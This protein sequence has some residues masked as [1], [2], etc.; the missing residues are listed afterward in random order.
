M[1]DEELNGKRILAVPLN[2]GLGHATRLVPLLQKCIDAGAVIIIGGSPQHIS[3]MGEI[4]GPMETVS[5]PYLNIRLSPHRSQVGILLIQLPAIIVTIIREHFTLRQIVRNQNIDMVIS[6]NCFGLWNR[7]VKS[8][9][10]THQLHI[11][12]PVRTKFLEKVINAINHWFIRRFDECW[13]PDIE[14]GS[15]FAGEL[16]HPPIHGVKTTYIGILSRF[17]SGDPSNS[18]KSRKLLVIISGPEKQRSEFENIIQRQIAELPG[19]IEYNIVRGL[20]GNKEE[21]PPG[22]HNHVPS[23]RLEQMIRGSHYIVCRSGYSTIMDLIALGK[24]ALLVP[25]PG[26]REQEYIAEHLQQKGYFSNQ[27]QSDFNLNK[28][29]EEADNVLINHP[30]NNLTRDIQPETYNR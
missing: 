20:P 3:L 23:G 14:T 27:K 25:T 13:V 16:S 19:N 6:D 7:S 15:G 12:V 1:K 4:L 18:D 2:W 17:R 26:Q 21:Q 28:V 11:K 8:I 24:T 9:F 10:I 5:L 29:I 22:W 30:S